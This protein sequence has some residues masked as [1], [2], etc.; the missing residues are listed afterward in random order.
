[1]DPD[2]MRRIGQDFINIADYWE[3]EELERE[4]ED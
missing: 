1:M 2:V 4:Q 3:M